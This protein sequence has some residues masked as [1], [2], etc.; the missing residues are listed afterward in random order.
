MVLG[1]S[2][3]V[4]TGTAIR[5]DSI[6]VRDYEQAQLDY[7]RTRSD[8]DQ[9]ISTGTVPGDDDERTV[10]ELNSLRDLVNVAIDSDRRVIERSDTRPRF[11]VLDDDVRYVFDPPPAVTGDA[12]PDTQAGIPSRD[13]APADSAAHGA[14]PTDERDPYA[15]VEGEDARR[16]DQG[17]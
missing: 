16:P 14:T 7:A 1:I 9:W 13:S 6:S 8:L 11:V 15:S 2:G 5:R 12:Q 17:S 3:A 10:V 4:L